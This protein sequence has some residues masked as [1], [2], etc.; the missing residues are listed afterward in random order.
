MDRASI[1]NFFLFLPLFSLPNLKKSPKIGPFVKTSHKK[2][3]WT[4]FSNNIPQNK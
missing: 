3:T 4:G 2:E 1:S